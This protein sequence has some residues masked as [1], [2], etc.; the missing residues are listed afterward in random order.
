MSCLRAGELPVPKPP[1]LI[2]FRA[3]LALAGGVLSCASVLAADGARTSNP[4]LLRG[5]YSG[6]CATVEL[7][8]VSPPSSVSP[9]PPVPVIQAP[10][11][12]LPVS[13]ASA[14]QT[15]ATPPPPIDLNSAAPV[16]SL[17]SFA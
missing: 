15:T 3:L 6:G 10:V 2:G 9:I 7:C 16:T 1:I 5:T 8:A 17:E 4:D 11:V 14:P 13:Q 12:Q